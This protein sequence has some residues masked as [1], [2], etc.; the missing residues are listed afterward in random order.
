MKQ[1][2][3]YLVGF[4]TCIVLLCVYLENAFGKGRV[5]RGVEIGIRA[6]LKYLIDHMEP[7]YFVFSGCD[8]KKLKARENS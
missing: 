3:S 2:I 1:F 8:Y 6:F 7:R 4:C 5:H